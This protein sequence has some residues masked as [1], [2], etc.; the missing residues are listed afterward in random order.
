SLILLPSTVREKQIEWWRKPK[1][2]RY[3]DV[4]R[5][6]SPGIPLYIYENHRALPR[7]FCAQQVV[8][9]TPAETLADLQRLRSEDFLSEMLVEGTQTRVDDFPGT[10]GRVETQHYSP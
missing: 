5:S 3:L 2:A 1:L 6:R 4:I 8:R 10:A 7:A 9:Q